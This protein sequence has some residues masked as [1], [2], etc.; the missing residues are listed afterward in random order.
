MTKDRTRNRRRHGRRAKLAWRQITGIAPKFRN[1]RHDDASLVHRDAV[2]HIPAQYIDL[3]DDPS[4]EQRDTVVL[5]IVLL[6]VVFIAII[7][8]FVAQ[9]P[10]KAP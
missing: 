10:T 6:A 5:V 7:T 2:R 4:P 3:G 9:M 8:Y 1:A